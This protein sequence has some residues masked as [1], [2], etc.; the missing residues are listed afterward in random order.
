MSQKYIKG[1]ICVY[2]SYG[3]YIIEVEKDGWCS[4]YITPAGNYS[5]SGGSCGNSKEWVEATPLEK[6]WLQECKRL[7]TTIPF[8]QIKLPEY[9]EIY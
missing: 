7:R 2:S 4:C 5:N 9:A 8:D 3:R 6:L 1:D